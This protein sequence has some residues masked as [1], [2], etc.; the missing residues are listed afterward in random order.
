MGTIPPTPT[1]TTRWSSRC[2]PRQPSSRTSVRVALAQ[3]RRVRGRLPP[4]PLRE[5]RHKIMRVHG[6]SVAATFP[7][8]SATDLEMRL[9]LT[10]STLRPASWFYLRDKYYAAELPRAERLLCE[11][12]GTEA[13]VL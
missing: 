3:P 11:S 10:S 13:F 2:T 6:A 9:A 7:A 1:P 8:V 12:E 5:L 4:T